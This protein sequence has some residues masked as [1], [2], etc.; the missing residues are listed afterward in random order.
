LGQPLPAASSFRLSER[1][2]V[3][4]RLIR[5]RSYL[6]RTMSPGFTTRKVLNCTDWRSPVTRIVTP[7]CSP[8]PTD[9]TRASFP[10]S[11]ALR[12]S[13]ST[14]LP[15]G[16]ESARCR[17]LGDI[18]LPIQVLKS[19]PTRTGLSRPQY[20][21]DRYILS[22]NTYT[23]CFTSITCVSDSVSWFEMSQGGAPGSDFWQLDERRSLG[24]DGSIEARRCL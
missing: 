4:P 20:E 15:G 14:S 12:L 18:R 2:A 13:T 24:Q 21:Y 8:I 3:L 17:W 9:S 5:P 6:R 22:I 7:P 19:Q 1:S 10:R 23:A 16:L 11:D